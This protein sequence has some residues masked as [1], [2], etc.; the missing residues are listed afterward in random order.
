MIFTTADIVVIAILLFFGLI[1]LV[2][3][4]VNALLS[5]CKGFLSLIVAY[6]LAPHFAN[7]L[8]TTFLNDK[9]NGS[10]LNWANN[11]GE[12]FAQPIPEGG[13]SQM[14]G[15]QLNLP[16]FLIDFLNSLI[17]NNEIV[18]GITL[19]QFLADT[20]TYYVLLIIAFFILTLISRIIIALISR[21][22]TKLV[23]EGGGFRFVN[24]LLGFFVGLGKGF[25][26]V[27]VIFFVARFLTSWFTGIDNLIVQYINPDNPE[28]GIARWIYNNN[29]LDFIINKMLNPDNALA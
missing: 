13:I 10:L 24:R 2:K 26:I 1:G 12:L 21:I 11:K 17:G 6:F 22:L 7:Y 20:L 18:S 9:I 16:Q 25:L 15:D 29:F 8:Q 28:F 14:V 27:L 5:I 3:G 19:G 4:F 23:E